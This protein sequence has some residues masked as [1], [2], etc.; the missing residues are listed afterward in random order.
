MDTDTGRARSIRSSYEKENLWSWPC[1]MAVPLCG[2]TGNKPRQAFLIFS[3]DGRFLI[4]FKCSFS[5]ETRDPTPTPKGCKFIQGSRFTILSCNLCAQPAERGDGR[6]RY[7]RAPPA[8]FNYLNYIEQTQNSLTISVVT[9]T[10]KHLLA[11]L[12]LYFLLYFFSSVSSLCFI[13]SFYR[14]CWYPPHTHTYVAI[15][16]RTHIRRNTHP[17]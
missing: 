10:R 7:L 8:P 4:C 5:Q 3:R 12:S 1:A 16:V 13:L 17:C 2:G 9:T 11:Q 15:N 6:E 14:C